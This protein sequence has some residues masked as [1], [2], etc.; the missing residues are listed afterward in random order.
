MGSLTVLRSPVL[1]GCG[2]F[3]DGEQR[4]PS[5]PLRKDGQ[6]KARKCQTHPPPG[7]NPQM[8]TPPPALG[9]SLRFRRGR[10]GG[11]PAQVC[12]HYDFLASTRKQTAA[13]KPV[14]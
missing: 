1:P 12:A 6:G 4:P 8:P 5:R 14:C 2:A 10:H 9:G 7:R 11:S 13:P 3:P